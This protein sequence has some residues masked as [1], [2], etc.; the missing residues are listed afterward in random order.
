MRSLLSSL[1]LLA[2]SAPA[3]A[4]DNGAPEPDALALIGIAAAVG[5]AAAISK[6]RKK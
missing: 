4:I 6:K 5:V 2:L 1:I 3:F